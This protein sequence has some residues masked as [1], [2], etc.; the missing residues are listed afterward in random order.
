MTFIEV[1]ICHR[2]GP[3]KFRA[4]PFIHSLSGR[5]TTS[6]QYFTGKKTWLVKS[7]DMK[8][9]ALET[10]GDPANGPPVITSDVISQARALLVAVYTTKDDHFTSDDMGQVR[11]YKFLNNKS[12][13]LKMLPSTQT[14]SCSTLGV[15]LW[16]L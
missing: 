4:L 3:A 1:D 11:A 14:L 13:Q 5:D 2:M 7:K 8:M 10:F 16:Q 15:Q 12:T 6:Y 9:S